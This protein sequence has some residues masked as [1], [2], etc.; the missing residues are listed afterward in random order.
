[1]RHL[2]LLVQNGAL[3]GDHHVGDGLLDFRLR[4]AEFRVQDFV[5]FFDGL[6]VLLAD[7]L[8]SQRENGVVQL[9]GTLES[10]ARRL[11]HNGAERKH[12]VMKHHVSFGLGGFSQLFLVPAA[13][14]VGLLALC[15]GRQPFRVLAYFTVLLAT[16][17]CYKVR[18]L[19]PL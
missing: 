14:Y 13:H 10:W 9:A 7:G 18:D 1:M 17:L 12:G 6:F 19:H 11:D 3:V 8:L 5:H 16:I 2:F 4:I 15:R